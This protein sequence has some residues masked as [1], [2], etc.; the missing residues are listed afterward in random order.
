M[1]KLKKL[2]I[3]LIGCGGMM[4]GHARC[5]ERM[6]GVS[7]VAVADPVE[8]RRNAMAAKFGAKGIYADTKIFFESENALDAVLIAVP[9]SEHKGIEEEAIA[10]NLHFKI[11]K[12]MT[13]NMA[14]AARIAAGVE[15]A[16]LVTAVG[17]QDRYMEITDRMADEIKKTDIGLIH[18]TWAGGV[19]GVPWWRKRATG[20]GQ[21][22]EQNIHL[23]DMVRYLFGEFESVYALKTG[24]IVKEDDY[25]GYDVED[26]STAVFRMKSG[27]TATFFSAC[28]LIS[29]GVTID[30]GIIAL[31]RQRSLAYSLRKNLRVVT[32]GADLCY[33]HENDQLY[34][35]NLAFFNAV[36]KADPTA[37][38]SPYG[39]A[40]KSLEACFAANKSMDSGKV[41]KL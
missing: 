36:R 7:V 9:P 18:A 25:P 34:D 39:D 11:E 40:L 32:R 19:P 33:L 22:I 20:G 12:P 15:K 26:S 16:G 2:K 14:Q 37:V 13:L 3:G 28:F 8:E 21:L 24:G 30:N 38:R 5:I 23:V 35:S 1:A 10:R 4:N 17:F 41:I 29:G 6:E 27:A 31:G